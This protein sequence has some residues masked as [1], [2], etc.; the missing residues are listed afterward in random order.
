LLKFSSVTKTIKTEGPFVQKAWVSL[1]AVAI[2]ITSSSALAVEIE[3]PGQNNNF[4]FTQLVKLSSERKAL[5]I[6]EDL[7][8]KGFSVVECQRN[9]SDEVLNVGT[10]CMLLVNTWLSG[11]E[12]VRQ[13]FDGVFESSLNSE[14]KLLETKWSFKM[15]LG[16]LAISSFIGGVSGY[17]SLLSASKGPEGA[18]GMGGVIVGTVV[19]TGVISMIA[20]ETYD[21][22]KRSQ[23]SIESDLLKKKPS[24]D[25]G[26][27]QEISKDIYLLFKRSLIV[28]MAVNLSA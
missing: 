28:A 19:I 16:N 12:D 5:Y 18:M 21:Y 20:L 24:L 25:P 22:Y 14:A 13:A 9:G 7:Q 11:A 10:K 15:S 1:F 6:V 4:K 17:L 8:K 3:K 23:K 26:A 2:F 27:V